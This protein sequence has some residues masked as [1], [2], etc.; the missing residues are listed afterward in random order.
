MSHLSGAAG[1]QQ[2]DGVAWA[3]LQAGAAA[4]Y[5]A[6]RP[7]GFPRESPKHLFYVKSPDVSM[8]AMDS[9]V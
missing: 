2:G 3:G 9:H 8:L 1:G 4:G 5:G 6:P 7:S